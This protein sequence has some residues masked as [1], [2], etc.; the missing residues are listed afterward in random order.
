[1]YRRE[2]LRVLTVSVSARAAF[3]DLAQQ[4]GFPSEGYGCKRGLTPKVKAT[5]VGLFRLAGVGRII[6][7]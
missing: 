2:E 4:A 5:Q 6:R 7:S 3:E 1:M